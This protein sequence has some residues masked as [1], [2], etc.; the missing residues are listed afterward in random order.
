MEIS[1][2]GSAGELNRL[3]L[4]GQE[5][6]RAGGGRGSG[7]APGEDQVAI[8]R[9]AQEIQRVRA[10]AEEPDE[11]RTARVAQLTQ[12]IESGAYHVDSRDVADAVIRYTLTDAAL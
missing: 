2:Y 12:A 1:G 11:T 10:L 9:Q 6:D 3:L 5:T 8:S 4:G 7:P